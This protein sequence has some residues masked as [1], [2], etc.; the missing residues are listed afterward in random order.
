MRRRQPKLLDWTWIAV[1][2]VAVVTAG[3]GSKRK[4][5]AGHAGEDAR[6]VAPDPPLPPAEPL[7]LGKPDLDG[8][9]YNRGPARPPFVRAVQA[10]R[11]SQWA[12]VAAASRE[13]LAL[14]PGHL[15]A[16]WTLATA[17]ARQGAHD[18][19][20]APLS[21]AVAGDWMRWG[22]RSLED[23]ALQ[24]FL[25]SAHGPRYR[26][27]VEI[28]RERYRRTLAG[29]VLVVGRRGAP[30]Y[31]RRKGAVTINHRSELYAHD[32]ETRR[33]VRVS[34]T[35]GALVGYVRAP[36]GAG[37]VYASYRRVV[38]PAA[39]V[40]YLGEVRVGAVDLDQGRMSAREV[41]FA[42]VAA[43]HLGYE[44]G[45][46]GGAPVP[47]ARVHAAR[48]GSVRGFTLDFE[49]GQAQELAA[50]GADAGA[51]AGTPAGA[52]MPAGAATLVVTAAGVHERRIPV[53]GVAADWDDAGTA[54]AFRLQRTRR[55]VTLAAGESANGHSMVWS[56]TRA[57]LAFATAAADPCAA[58]AAARRVRLYVVEAATGK[59]HQVA[60][61]EGDFAPVWLDDARL[62]YADASAV[63]L[64]DAVAG[65]AAVRL[66]ASGGVGTNRLPGRL[67]WISACPALDSG[68]G[69][70]AA[71]QAPG[72]AGPDSAPADEVEADR[73]A[74]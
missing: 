35:D 48:D 24:G 9:A 51:G 59:L 53:D 14:D 66:E 50:P 55:T 25:R 32:L 39:G 13:A 23:E 33:Y 37:L 15:E 56:P 64:V 1:A 57:R 5:P 2:A 22:E 8:Y 12:T 20:L 43:L 4:D 60:E 10:E 31:P 61:S 42:D 73:P 19:V 58:D 46:D 6:A 29:G 40:P 34:R 74:Q 62:A 44:A 70:D 68:A 7:A 11:A 18:Q 27:L 41:A 71:A 28:Y 54:G 65:D 3:C 72:P 47:V 63:V 30:W 49:N 17:L 45:P 16:S 36:V 52:T 38:V 21:V 67:P 69:T 26:D